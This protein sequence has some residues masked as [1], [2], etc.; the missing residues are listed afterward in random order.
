MRGVVEC[1]PDPV[2]GLAPLALLVARA[3]FLAVGPFDTRWAVGEFI[4]WYLRAGEQGLKTV[5]L[6]EVVALR[7][8]HRTNQGILKGD[9]RGDYIRIVKAARDRR[10]RASGGDVSDP[11]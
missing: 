11:G 9:L 10:R 4:D 3:A 5:M 1:P 8:L 7:R 6:P 2:A